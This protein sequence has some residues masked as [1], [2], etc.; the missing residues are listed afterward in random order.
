MDKKITYHEQVTRDNTIKLRNVLTTLPTF[1]R[2][3]FRAIEPNTSAKT[4]ISY[5]YDVRLFFT[6]LWQFPSGSLRSPSGRYVRSS[7]SFHSAAHKC[8]SE[9]FALLPSLTVVS[10]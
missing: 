5:V 9:R 3:Y 6:F 10:A 7:T 8:A 2:D 1:C 4:R